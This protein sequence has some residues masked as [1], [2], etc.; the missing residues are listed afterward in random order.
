MVGTASEIGIACLEDTRVRVRRRWCEE[1]VMLDLSLGIWLL[2]LHAKSFA[3]FSAFQV[4][5]QNEE[6]QANI[7]MDLTLDWDR[8]RATKIQQSICKSLPYPRLCSSVRI[9]RRG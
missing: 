8:K 5:A 9:V 4:R 3:C 1:E 2:T 6:D 7:L